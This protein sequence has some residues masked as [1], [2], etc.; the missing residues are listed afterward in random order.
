MDRDGGRKGLSKREE[1]AGV[2]DT[3]KLLKSQPEDEQQDAHLGPSFPGRIQQPFSH[4]FKYLQ[5]EVSWEM[6]ALAQLSKDTQDAVFHTI[7]K[8]L[9]LKDRRALQDFMDMLDGDPLAHA[10]GFGGTFLSEMGEDLRNS[11]SRSR[12]HIIYILDAIMALNDTQHELLAQSMEK[13]ILLQQR[14]LVRSILEPNFKYPLSI[15]FRL[16]PEL[17]AQLQEDGVA[18]TFA[19]LQECGLRMEPGS[20]KATWDLEAKKPLC[21]LY[22]ALSGLQQLVG[23]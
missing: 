12:S 23:A 7:L 17:L 1:V 3:P 13:R 5:E 2:Q 4:D 8:D 20:P 19:L 16:E 6:E 18:V 9:K 15:P 14:E 21:A 10:D 22:A 11:W